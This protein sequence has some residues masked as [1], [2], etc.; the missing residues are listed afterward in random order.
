MAWAVAIGLALASAIPMIQLNLHDDLH[1]FEAP[2]LKVMVRALM[3]ATAGSVL[4]LV[5][6]LLPV[7]GQRLLFAGLILLSIRFSWKVAAGLAVLGLIEWVLE[8]YFAL[9]DR[10]LSRLVTIVLLLAVLPATLWVSVRFALPKVDRL[11]I[12]EKTARRL[13]LI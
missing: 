8:T 12:G 3:I 13:R 10:L 9:P 2:F 1:P 6:Q 7:P 4:A 11:T 5:I